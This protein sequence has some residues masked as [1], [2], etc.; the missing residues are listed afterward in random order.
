MRSASLLFAA[1][2]GVLGLCGQAVPLTATRPP[3]PRAAATLYAEFCAS[4]HGLQL[5][6]GKGPALLRRDGRLAQNDAALVD[7]ILA[8]VP[9]RG[10]PAFAAAL[11]RGEARLLVGFLRQQAST[12]PPPTGGLPSPDAIQT[13]ERASFR[14]EKIVGG[15]D[16]PWAFAFLPDGQRLLFTERRGE[17]FALDLAPGSIPVKITGV[18][19]VTWQ[20]EAGLMDVAVH[21]QH[22]ENGW[23]YLSFSDQAPSY[24]SMLKIVRGRIRDGRWTDEETIFAAAADDYGF[25]TRSYGG[26]LAFHDGYLFFTVGDRWDQDRAQD[27]SS[28]KGKVHRVRPD[29]RIP[30]DNPFVERAGAL[31]SIWSYGHRNPQ[32]LA[33]DPA[34]GALWETEHGPRGGDEL[35]LI[36]RGA[37]YGWPLATFGVNYDGT[38]VAASSTAPG[39]IAPMRHWTPSIATCALAF[40]TGDAFQR[41]RGHLFLGSLAKQQLWRFVVENGRIRH[42]ELVAQGLGR[43]RDIDTGPDGRLY[44]SLETPGARN[45]SIVRL[46]PVEHHAQQ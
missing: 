13:S 18:P 37:N 29:G 28:P 1:G 35:N 12:R 26:R 14:I 39:T 44:L 41:W 19:N 36:K 11:T 4:C 32:G 45:G 16:V 5:E 33:F 9:E 38:P 40:Y 6:G 46:V 31:G 3:T 15:L 2:L 43:I 27:L 7:L 21:P 24:E 30:N 34:S 17:L 20:D 25:G 10:M 23:V 42:E 22:A 8:G